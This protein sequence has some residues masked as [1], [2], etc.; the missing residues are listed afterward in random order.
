MTLMTTTITRDSREKRDGEA[1]HV[2]CVR[3]P[4][5]TREDSGSIVLL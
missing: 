1:F 4:T 5:A 3:C 2:V